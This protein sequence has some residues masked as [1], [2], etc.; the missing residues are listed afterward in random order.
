MNKYHVFEAEIQRLKDNKTY[1][2][3][4]VVE[5]AN[6]ATI[7]LNGKEVINLSS[8]NYLGFANHPRLKQ[9]AINA[10]NTYGVGAGA[11]K[12]IAGHMKLHQELE[13]RLAAFKGEEAAVLFQSG[14]S[15]NAGVISAITDKEDLI[16]SD[17]L[18][19]ASIIDGVR[20]SRASKKVY[21]HND[22]AHLRELLTELRDNH[23]QVL[24]ITDGV[25][26]MDGDLAH[27]PEIV[28]LAKEFNALTYVDDAHGSGVLG[29]SGRGTV[30][31]FNLHG[32][33]DFTI[34]TLSKALGVVGGYVACSHVVKEYLSFKA[35]PLLF[36]TML[37]PAVAGA[38][39]EAITI[40]EETDEYT[41]RLWDNANYFKAKAK[42][43]GFDIGHSETPITPLFV[44]DEAK[45]V[46]F[47]Q[48]LLENGV[49][50][51]PIVFPTV[52]VGLGR[53]RIMISA[54]HTKEQ[55][56][57]A[58]TIIEDVG[59]ALAII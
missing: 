38:L 35:R 22:M 9:A 53:L 7:I 44:Y 5:S 24:I 12:T 52:P 17:E 3:I 43:L 4:P 18:N 34:G 15:C 58:L 19:H 40:L 36:S 46:E 54:T 27:L 49:F 56:D 13:E 39:L 11:V 41:K 33:I 47:S 32:E 57:Q 45:T 29:R 51:S 8:N 16:L 23:R 55:L 31:H 14:F 30:D 20:L 21:R 50:V 42:D 26:S 10:I 37:P 25:F 6:D 1:R 28:A 48:R 59:K 2:T